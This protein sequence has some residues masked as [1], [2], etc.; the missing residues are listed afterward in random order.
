M[1]LIDFS[2]AYNRQCHNRLLTCYSDLGTPTYLLKILKSYL[3]K[4]KMVFRHRGKLSDFYDLPAGGAQGTNIGIL[5]F[6]VY[7][8]SCGVPFDKMMECLNHEHKEKYIGRPE[9]EHSVPLIYNLGCVKIWH[10][11]LPQPDA[12]VSDTQ[13]VEKN[14]IIISR[15]DIK[16][17]KGIGLMMMMMTRRRTRMWRTTARITT[18]TRLSQLWN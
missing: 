3:T 6:L 18:I 9:E 12:H 16:N 4:R 17:V 1:C 5:N 15:A 14:Q 10:P 13:N 2:K 8:N 7:V 11:I